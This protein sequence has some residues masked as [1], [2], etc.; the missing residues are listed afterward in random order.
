MVNPKTTSFVHYLHEAQALALSL[1]VELV[2]SHV[3]TAADIERTIASFALVPNG[4]LVVPPDITTIVHRDLMV[5]LAARHELPAVYA[6]RTFVAAGELMSYGVDSVEPCRQAATYVDRILRGAKPAD[7][8]VRRRL[9]TRRS[10]TSR[11][12]RNP[13]AE[14]TEGHCAA[15]A[16]TL[17][18]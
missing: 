12:R 17:A 7:L 18:S 9:S 11:P 14:L 8:P 5:G 10:S 1:K 6:Y 3:E 2:P 16:E 15:A 4:G 13:S